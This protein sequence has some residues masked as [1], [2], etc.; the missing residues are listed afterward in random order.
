MRASP[1]L[2]SQ[3]VFMH[4]YLHCFCPQVCRELLNRYPLACIPVIMISA[5]SNEEN[6][7]EGLNSGSVD[8]VVCQTCVCAVNS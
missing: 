2:E 5:K 3:N 8:Y 4:S 6:I 7:V 1:V